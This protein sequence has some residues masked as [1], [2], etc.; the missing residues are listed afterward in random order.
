[1]TKQ[2]T[3]IVHKI[4]EKVNRDRGIRVYLCNQAVRPK[5]LRKYSF[6]WKDVT[7]KNCLKI[8]KKK[9]KQK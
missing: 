6:R 1:M 2:R 3:L 4:S 7:C 9:E 5:Y 8:K